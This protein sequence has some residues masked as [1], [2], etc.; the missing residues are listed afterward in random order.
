MAKAGTSKSARRRQRKAAA[1]KRQ[2]ER[3]KAAS[4]PEIVEEPAVDEVLAEL[5]RIHAEYAGE[6]TESQREVERL[7][8]NLASIANIR[9]THGHEMPVERLRRCIEIARQAPEPEQDNG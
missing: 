3:A 8:A 1:E 5:E 2:R 4:T 9:E 6:L 7:N